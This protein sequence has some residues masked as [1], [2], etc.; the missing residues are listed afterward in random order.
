MSRSHDKMTWTLPDLRKQPGHEVET[1]EKSSLG[2]SDKEVS[3]P[4]PNFNSKFLTAGALGKE[5]AKNDCTF[6]DGLQPSH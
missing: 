5:N 4:N 2:Q 3:V 6:C 1:R